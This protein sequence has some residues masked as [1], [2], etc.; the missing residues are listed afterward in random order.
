MSKDRQLVR[1]HFIDKS[2]KT[3]SID[4]N[5][6]AAALRDLVVAR[7][8]LKEDACFALFEKKDDWERC[9]EPEE[10]PTELQLQW[11]KE[12][13]ERKKNDSEPLFVFKKKI[14]LKDDDREMEDPVAKSLI[15]KQALH[16]VNSSEYPVTVADATKLAG[17]QCQI[18]CGDHN[19]AV[20]NTAFLVPNISDFIPKTLMGN[21][22][23]Q[24]W[25]NNVLEAH[26][27]LI[28]KSAEDAMTEYLNIVKTWGYYGSTFYPPC[29]SVGNRNLHSKVVIGVNYEGI[30]LLK[31][32]TKVNILSFNMTIGRNNRTLTNNIWKTKG[33]FKRILFYGNS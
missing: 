12:K 3:F 22:R 27:S 33:G 26:E 1:V 2:C 24:E 25:A 18:V 17:L 32:K 16:S 15:F 6:T 14:F 10:K 8:E 23:P 20:H 31:P 5:T 21:K 4:Q 29:K 19:N 7:I 11:E 9:L 30:R 28:G 13:A